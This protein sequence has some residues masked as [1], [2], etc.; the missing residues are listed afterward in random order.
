VIVYLSVFV[1]VLTV[2]ALLDGVTRHSLLMECCAC[3]A[4]PLTCTDPTLP[5]CRP[6]DPIR[7]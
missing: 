4:L 1:L 6:G 5:R 2:V 3:E 7:N